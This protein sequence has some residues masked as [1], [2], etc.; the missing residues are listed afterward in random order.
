MGGVEKLKSWKVEKFISWRVEEL[1][2]KAWSELSTKKGKIH[3]AL[4]TMHYA[5]IP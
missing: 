1:K 3:H 2:N 4:Y 5:N